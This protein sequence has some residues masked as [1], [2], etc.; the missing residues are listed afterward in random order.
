[1]QRYVDGLHARLAMLARF[2]N[3]GR[4]R[5]DLGVGYRSIVHGSH[6]VFYRVSRRD[7]VVVRVLHVRMSPDRHLP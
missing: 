7:L 1:M 3:S 5:D 4:R 2:P 6:I